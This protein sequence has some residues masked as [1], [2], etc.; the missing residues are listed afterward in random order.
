MQDET[1]ENLK[2]GAAPE[3][4]SEDAEDPEDTESPKQGYFIKLIVM[5][6]ISIIILWAVPYYWIDQNPEPKHVSQLE[7]LD[8]VSLNRSGLLSIDEAVLIETS[9]KI[10]QSAIRIVTEACPESEI[11]YAKALF[12]YVRDNI[13]YLKDP[14]KEYI[15]L[16]E[17]TI[18]GAGDCEDKAILLY[19]LMK[20]IGIRSRIVLIPK[21]AYNEILIPDAPRRYKQDNGWIAL[22]STCRQ[23]SFGEIPLSSSGMRKRYI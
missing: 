13:Q 21:H 22:D 4:S 9:P 8:P 7:D 23:C 2:T 15:Q 5:L 11:C 20:A 1:I 10:R 16:P 19:S 18:L 17:E 12:Y 14:E 3:Q 6:I